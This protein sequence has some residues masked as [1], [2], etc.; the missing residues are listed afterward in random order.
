VEL[1]GKGLKDTEVEALKKLKD[2]RDLLFLNRRV[3]TDEIAEHLAS[4]IENQA[5]DEQYNYLTA[6]CTEKL[7][8][9]KYE[10]VWKDFEEYQKD[11]TKLTYIALG[12][13]AKL[14]L[15]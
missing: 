15:H 10:K 7:V 2:K 1:S 3:I 6:I 14:L 12:A 11:D 4:S 5:K 8:D 9:E 13:L